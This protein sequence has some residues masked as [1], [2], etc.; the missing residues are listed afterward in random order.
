MTN[1]P[2]LQALSGAAQT[3]PPIWMMRQ[4]GRY[5]PEYR[6]LRT[7]AKDFLTFCYTPEMAAEATLQPITR[8]GFDAAIIFSDILV[9]PDALDQDVRFVPGEGP[10]LAALENSAAIDALKPEAIEEFLAPVY[11]ALRNVRADLPAE[12]ALVG[13]AGAPWTLA[14]YMLEGSGSRDYARA[15]KFALAEPAAFRKLIGILEDVIARHLI[16]QIEAGAE[17][18]QLFDSWA[19]ALPAYGVEAWSLGPISRIADRVKAAKPNARV[20]AFPRGADAF[21]TAYAAHPT[22]DAVSLGQSLPVRMFEAVWDAGA[23]PQGNLDPVTLIAGGEVLQ[24]EID[25]ILSAN[26]GKPHVFNLGHGIT[27]ETP[28]AHVEELV[29]RVRTAR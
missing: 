26:A 21:I 19:G 28:I 18:V 9:I 2:F 16:Q 7:D 27:P 1:K 29:A 23:V 8:F 11:E 4:A 3:V 10:K 15:R 13:F 12:T 6:K 25:G 17:A 20:I 14:A 5:L 22:I 24:R